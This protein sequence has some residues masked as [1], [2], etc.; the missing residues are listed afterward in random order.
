MIG[1]YWG[2]AVPSPLETDNP[3]EDRMIDQVV[4]E[5]FRLNGVIL[6]PQ[7]VIVKRCTKEREAK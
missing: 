3:E 5:G 2:G 7:E 4:R 6:R 1:D